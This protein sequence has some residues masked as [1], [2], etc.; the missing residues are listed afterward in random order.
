MPK[1]LDML[2]D[3]GLTVTD[4]REQLPTNPDV[5]FYKR[6]KEDIQG[7]VV[8]HTA[9]WRKATAQGIAYWCVEKRDFPGMPYA[10]YINW[11]DGKWTGA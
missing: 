1:L 9:G 6:D 3:A 7:I 11:P 4:L 5:P 8:H 2:T 10:F